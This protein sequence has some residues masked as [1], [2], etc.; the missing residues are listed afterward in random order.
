MS[1]MSRQKYQGHESTDKKRG[2]QLRRERRK[3]RREKL[4]I[5]HLIQVF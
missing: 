3:Q 2:M 5:S 4:E 1:F